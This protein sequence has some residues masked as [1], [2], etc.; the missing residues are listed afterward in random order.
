MLLTPAERNGLEQIQA[1]LKNQTPEGKALDYKQQLNLENKEDKKELAR[2][3]ASFANAAGG[4]LVY[5][6]GE[7][8]GLPT[9]VLGVAC[10]DFDAL[11]LR[12][13]SVLA[14]HI[15]PKVPGLSY[16]KVDMPGSSPVIVV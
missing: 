16:G 9:D 3:V 11:K 8:A 10:Q 7:D 13:D 6:I 12:L 14:D 2:D 1:L 4:F 15:Q 5:G